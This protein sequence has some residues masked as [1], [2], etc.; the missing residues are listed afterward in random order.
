MCQG[1]RYQRNVVINGVFCRVY[2]KQAPC[3]GEEANVVFFCHGGA[4]VAS[5]HA[6]DI[7]LL[8][9]WAETGAVIIVPDYSLSPEN[10]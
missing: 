8:T 1:M 4:F 7:P 3:I 9:T 5:L 6:A 10:P 2:A